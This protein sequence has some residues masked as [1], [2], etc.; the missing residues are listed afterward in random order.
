M[1]YSIDSGKYVTKLPHK[2]DYDK[3]RS[4]ISDA[5]YAKII[6]GLCKKIDSQE[7]NTAGWIPGHDWTGTVYEPI[8]YACGR[9]KVQSGMFFG[10]IVFDYLMNRSDKV[11]GFGRFEKNGVP[12]EST[13]YFELVNPPTME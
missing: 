7:I 9:N 2:K 3:W 6:D 4:H 13:T 1:L 11:W 5:D 10:L 12:I 8:F